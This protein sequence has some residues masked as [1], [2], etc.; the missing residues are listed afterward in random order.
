MTLRNL[1]VR[2]KAETNQ[3]A[4]QLICCFELHQNAKPIR[5][6]LPATVAEQVLVMDST[7]YESSKK[8]ITDRITDASQRMR[9]SAFVT[10][11]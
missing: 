6:T 8:H 5:S 1:R 10:A 3:L 4:C 9:L 7:R 11:P 2:D